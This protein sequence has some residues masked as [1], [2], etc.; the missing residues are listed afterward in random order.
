MRERRISSLVASAPLIPEKISRYLPLIPNRLLSYNLR[1]RG[2]FSPK[3]TPR[4]PVHPRSTAPSRPTASTLLPIRFLSTRPL[5]RVPLSYN[6]KDCPANSYE[7]PRGK[8]A[9]GR[10]IHRFE[11]SWL[12][13]RTPWLIQKAPSV[14]S[15]SFPVLFRSPP[16]DLSWSDCFTAKYRFP[17]ASCRAKSCEPPS[18]A[19]WPCT[20]QRRWTNACGMRTF[21]DGICIQLSRSGF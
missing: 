10:A 21:R 14:D 16:S 11:V 19:W 17:S 12:E 4:A 1:K 3:S 6:N 2:P 15:N 8:L 18:S 9:K 13:G 7:P 20:R 5:S